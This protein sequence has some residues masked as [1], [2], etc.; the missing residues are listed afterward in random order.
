MR[1]LMQQ[2]ARGV[3]CATLLLT[4]TSC[5]ESPTEPSSGGPGRVLSVPYSAQQTPVWCWAA[6]SE[7][8]LQYYGRVA[9]QC[10]ILSAW[11]RF[12]CCTFPGPC[13]TTAPIE[14]IQATLAAVGVG[15]QRVLSP[16]SFDV[17]RAEIDAGRPLILAYRGSFSGHVVVLYGYDALGR[18]YINDPLYGQV[19]G[20]P[21]GATFTYNGQLGW[22]ETLLGIR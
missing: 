16:V 5:N 17:V 21:Y 15:S 9:T 20:V 6:C 1:V 10:G 18:V 7:M 12:D 4:V 2:V 8:I 19:R 3:L 11:F 13:T 14:V 22:A